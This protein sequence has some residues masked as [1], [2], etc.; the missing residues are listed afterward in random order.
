[1][2]KFRDYT[3]TALEWATYAKPANISLQLW[4]AAGPLATASVNVP[5]Q[6]PD[7]VMGVKDWSE[8]EGMLQFLVDNG[9]V[10]DTGL[11]LTSGFV[12]IHLVRVIR[13]EFVK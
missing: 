11:T 6:L 9:L 5:Q 7:G 2:P 8:N 1:M 10:E 3:V 13:K 12:V 4:C